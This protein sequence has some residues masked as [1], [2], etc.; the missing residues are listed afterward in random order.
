VSAG[1][2]LSFLENRVPPL[3]VGSDPPKLLTLKFH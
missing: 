3:P 1:S 2:P